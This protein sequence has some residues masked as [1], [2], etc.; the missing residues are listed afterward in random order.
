MHLRQ[1]ASTVKPTLHRRRPGNTVC[2]A[3]L[4]VRP[5]R[6]K[7][8][9][10]N[11]Q[12]MH[13]H[14]AAGCQA[15]CLI[16]PHCG[17][18]HP[19]VLL[20]CGNMKTAAAS[21]S[22]RPGATYTPTKNTATPSTT[23]T[24]T[25]TTTTPKQTARDN[26]RKE[27]THLVPRDEPHEDVEQPPGRPVLEEAEELGEL[28]PLHLTQ[29]DEDREEDSVHSKQNSASCLFRGPVEKSCTRGQ[30]KDG[31]ER[32]KPTIKRARC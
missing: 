28:G 29:D 11:S 27:T 9:G 12:S 3:W 19:S 22:G 8:R 31:A 26:P 2:A 25:T 10:G 14:H 24:S 16:P 5:D 4:Q 17:A 13:V 21:G 30:T 1:A 15:S 18:R 23:S 6:V 7:A 32:R 20:L